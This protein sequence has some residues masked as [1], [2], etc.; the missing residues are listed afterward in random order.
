MSE[1]LSDLSR[2]LGVDVVD[3]KLADGSEYTFGLRL[4]QLAQPVGFEFRVQQT[5]MSTRAQL[6]M[7]SFPRD[8]LQTCKSS[9]TSRKGELH[10]VLESAKS[11]QVSIDFSVDG[12]RLEDLKDDSE[13][14]TIEFSLHKKVENYED[15]LGCLKLI[16]LMAFSM[17]IP[18]IT[19]ESEGLLE[20]VD[21]E[22]A[23]EG[24]K[25]SVTVNKYERSRVNRAICLELFGFICGGCDARM[26]DLYGPI[27][28]GVIHVHHLEPVSIMESPRP[29]NPATDLIPLC[30]NCH[31]IVHRKSPPIGIAE[32]RRIISL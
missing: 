5:L 3:A 14:E 11:S 12:T 27:G 23:V 4:Q 29:L 24:A 32:L 20:E 25:T 19:E 30:P 22:Y 6:F 8:L 10:G 26:A 13:W 16:V 17:M 28:E 21:V 2:A 15:A 18:L 9:F 31:T 7:D 1:A